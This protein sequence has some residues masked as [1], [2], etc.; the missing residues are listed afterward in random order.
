MT[1]WLHHC[2]YFD[3]LGKNTVT[4]GS[5]GSHLIK[6]LKMVEANDLVSMF[7]VSVGL[8][9]FLSLFLHGKICTQ[10]MASLNAL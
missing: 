7:T 3:N 5:E 10:S 2:L 6:K 4:Q 8:S 9:F 1:I